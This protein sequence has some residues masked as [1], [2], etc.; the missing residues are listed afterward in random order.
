MGI[1]TKRKKLGKRADQPRE[2]FVNFT[3]QH[4]MI[5]HALDQRWLRTTPCIPNIYNGR[6]PPVLQHSLVE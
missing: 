2:L 1:S 5:V 6:D 3:G 4:E